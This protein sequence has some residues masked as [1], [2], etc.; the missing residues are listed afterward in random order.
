MHEPV[1]RR[2]PV[3]V[4]AAW[5]PHAAPWPR[6]HAWHQVWWATGADPAWAWAPT[7]TSNT[8]SRPHGHPRPEHGRWWA[9]TR[10]AIA[11]PVVRVWQQGRRRTAAGASS[12]IASRVLRASGCRERQQRQLLRT[13]PA[14]STVCI[15]KRRCLRLK[16]CGGWRL[17]AIQCQWLFVQRAATTTTTTT[18]LA[19]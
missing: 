6:R 8:S 9:L 4:R 18:C 5:P 14:S 7:T 10:A 1:G 15:R 16:G 2:L 19:C 11:A 17:H 12:S 13:T 3:V